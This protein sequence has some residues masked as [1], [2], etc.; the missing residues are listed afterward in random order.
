VIASALRYIGY[1]WIATVALYGIWLGLRQMFF[2][3]PGLIFASGMGDVY[4]LTLIALP[5]IGLVG[6]SGKLKK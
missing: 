6:L 2:N 1:G 5:G 3:E 4:V